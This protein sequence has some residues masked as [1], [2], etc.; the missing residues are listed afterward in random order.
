MHNQLFSNR[1][2]AG[3]LLAEKLKKYK[4]ANAVVL[5]I[6]R[7]GVV[8]GYQIAKRLEI[9][10]DL[11]M[12]KKIGHPNNKEYAIGSVSLES[13]IISDVKDIPE[14]YIHNEILRIRKNLH[15]KYA[16]FMG[17][18][19]SIDVKNKIVILVDDGIA[20]GNTLLASIE[21]LRINKPEKIVVAVPVVPQ[22]TIE[23]VERVSDE[24]I[25]LL[26]PQYFT[27]VGAFYEDFEQVNEEEVIEMLREINSKK[28]TH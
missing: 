11:V 14:E 9:S 10:L 22:S 25:Y 13:A 26:V 1:T 17:N 19:E 20:T 12:S 24:F 5:A 4:S 18:R 21:M 23:E 8:L 28:Q 27:S 2:E 3:I 15:K 16:L 6:P 7:G